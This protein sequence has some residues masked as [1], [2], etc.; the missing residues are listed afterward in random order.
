[1]S[2][3]LNV[4]VFT[5]PEKP[6]VAER[7]RPFGPS[8]AFDPSTSTLI[9]G[10]NDAVLVDTLM[11]I[12]EAEALANW[13][14]LHHRRLTTI[15]ITHGHFDHFAGLSVLLQRFPDARAIATPKSVELMRK[16]SELI[17]FLR[18]RWPDQLPTSIV[19]AE[20]YADNVFALEGHELRIIEQGTPM[21]STPPRCTCHLLTSSSAATSSTTVPHV[22]W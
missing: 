10:E 14:A 11:T 3:A 13:V 12:A 7:V 15:Y 22:R 2:P 8:P 9:F 1:M 4:N 16:Q 5:A 6:M 18:K 20:P 17:P 19:L 21:P